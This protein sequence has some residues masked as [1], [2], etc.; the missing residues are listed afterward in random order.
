MT[1]KQYCKIETSVGGIYC[2]NKQFIKACIM[3]CMPQARHHYLYRQA[4]HKFIKDGL[5]Y[6]NKAR[7]LYK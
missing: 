7:K 3:Y 2:T 4:R 1:F 6:L 5:N